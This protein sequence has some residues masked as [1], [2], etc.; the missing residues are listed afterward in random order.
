M[1][2]EL[3]EFLNNTNNF[4]NIKHRSEADLQFELGY[5]FKVQKKNIITLG[6]NTNSKT[7]TTGV[8]KY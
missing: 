3:D 7:F 4:I 1:K 2:E 8:I 5:F 6:L